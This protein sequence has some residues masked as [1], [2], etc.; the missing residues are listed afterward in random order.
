VSGSRGR[1]TVEDRIWQAGV[2]I[3]PGRGISPLKA[4][5]DLDAA[6]ARLWR[7]ITARLMPSYFQAEHVPLLKAYVRHSVIA[8]TLAAR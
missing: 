5:G 3:I 2:P 4:P 8:D 6:E 7:S 1:A